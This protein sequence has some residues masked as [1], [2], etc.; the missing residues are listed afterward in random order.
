MTTMFAAI[1][2]PLAVVALLVYATMRG[3]RATA[4]LGRRPRATA[5]VTGRPGEEAPPTA[6]RRDETPDPGRVQRWFDALF[7]IA[8]DGCAYRDEGSACYLLPDLATD[9][10][11]WCPA[12]R[13]H[14]ALNP[15]EVQS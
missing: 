5:E 1:V 14:V 9:G 7:L 10:V 12:C 2:A 6:S 13:A 8:K 15:T 11:P 4:S 3:L